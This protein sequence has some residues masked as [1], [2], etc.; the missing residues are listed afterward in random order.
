[1]LILLR[2]SQEMSYIERKREGKEE[3]ERNIW[4]GEGGNVL[5]SPFP[6]LSILSL[7]PHFPSISIS[8]FS[9][10]F[11]SISSFSP[12]FIAAWLKGCSRLWHSTVPQKTWS[13]ISQERKELP[14]IRGCQN[15]QI[16][17]GFSDFQKMNVCISVFLWIWERKELLEIRR[18]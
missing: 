11:L 2:H 1:M 8:S 13:A 5:L 10:H 3:M 7:Y 6:S 9:L 4:I 18:C 17:K 12:H 15:D 16:L 14:E